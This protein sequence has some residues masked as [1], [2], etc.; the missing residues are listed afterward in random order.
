MQKNGDIR[1]L[2]EFTLSD[3]AQGFDMKYVNVAYQEQQMD[4]NPESTSVI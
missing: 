2:S 3:L 1:R 4:A